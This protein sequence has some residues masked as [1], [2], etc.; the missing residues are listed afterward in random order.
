MANYVKFMRGTFNAYEKLKTKDEDTLYFLSNNDGK[1]GSLYLGEKLIAGPDI[2]G[3]TSLQELTDVFLTPNLDY[4][5]ILM[6]DS[7]EMKWRDYSFDALTFRAATE[8]I[9]GATG[10]VPAPDYNERNMFLRGDGTWAVAGTECQ[11]FNNIKTSANQSHADALTQSTTGFILNKGDV[12][13]VQDFIVNGKYQYTSYIYNG[14]E[15]CALDKEYSADNIYFKSDISDLEISGK[16]LT[17][18]FELIVSQMQDIIIPDETTIIIDNSVLS[19]KDF[20]KCFY[21]YVP[22]DDT[23]PAHYEFQ[24][25]DE[26]HPWIAGLEPKVANQNGTLV[27]GWYEPNPTTIEGINS[28][29]TALQENVN[30]LSIK[31]DN[32]YTKLEIEEKIAAAPHLKRKVVAQIEDIDLNATDADE[33]IYMIPS[34]LEEDDNKYYEYIIIET[35]VVDDEGVETIVKAVEKVGSWEVDLSDYAKVSDVNAKAD[36]SEVDGLKA[37]V[38]GYIDVDGT[39]IPG[40]NSLVS[41]NKEAITTLISQVDAIDKTT[42]ALTSNLKT[43]NQTLDILNARADKADGNIATLISRA[44]KADEKLTALISRADKADEKIIVLENNFK[45]LDQKYVSINNFNTI[46]G[47]MDQ[48]LAQQ[49]NITDEIDKIN[50]RLTWEMI[51]EDDN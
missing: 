39:E 28:T 6:Y 3:A 34:G 47:N 40:L 17:E 30:T 4:D 33:Y 36:Q 29:I 51:P 26:Q 24:E 7:I 16:N 27:L 42:V 8:T 48:L 2:A 44:D 5:A 50:K 14:D 9:E 43:I 41:I 38:Y 49:I 22:A 23:Q 19:I 37:V 15:W 20:G 35:K 18:A 45:A 11:I 10:F 13:I 1:E 21:K 31:V 46:V 12:A 25:V 32:T